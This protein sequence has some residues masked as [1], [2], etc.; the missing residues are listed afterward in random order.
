MP[1]SLPVSRTSGSGSSSTLLAAFSMYVL[2]EP[3][4]AVGT[5][6]PGGDTVDYIHGL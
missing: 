6:F 4:H 5:P 1:L 2:R 3:A